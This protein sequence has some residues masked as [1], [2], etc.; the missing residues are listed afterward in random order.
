VGAA[1]VAE[2]V[3]SQIF[4]GDHGTTY[5]GNLLAMQSALYV[6]EQLTGTDEAVPYT[7]GG[8]IENVRAM[9][10]IFEERLQ[11]LGAKHAVI[12]SVRGAG[13]MR[14]LELKTDAQSVVAGALARGLLVNR[15]AGCVVRML[16]PFTVTVAEIDEAAEILDRVLSEVAG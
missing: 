8:L 1:L 2:R 4:A 3:A 16:P 15:T 11:A 7:G 14:A 6:L 5:G 13:I 9:G 12:A 10:P